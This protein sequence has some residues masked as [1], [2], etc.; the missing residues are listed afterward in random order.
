M[1]H[2]IRK[3]PEESRRVI[4]SAN[5]HAGARQ[6]NDLIDRLVNE[7]IAYGCD[8]QV[9]TDADEL[10]ELAEAWT[11]SGDLRAV[12]AAGGDG[13]AAFVANRVPHQTP[14]ALLPLG[15][16]NL[17]SKYLETTSDPV[18]LAE[19]IAL[20]SAVS[21]D[22]GQ[23]GERLFLLMCGVGFDAD[24][25]RRVHAERKGHIS[26]LAYA[27]PIFEA[28]RNYQYPEV[29]VT[30]RDAAGELQE[31]N[32]RW[33]FVV[34]VPRYAGGL[35]I[36]PD[37]EADDGLL[38]VCT[39]REGSFL[40]GLIYL[41]GVLFGQHQNWDDCG[42]M[43]A[44]EVR[45]TSTAEVPYQLDGDPGGVLPVEIKILPHRLSLLVCA[46]WARDHGY[47]SPTS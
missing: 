34:N 19:T 21:L 42:T 43:R 47:D 18:K 38:N 14:L 23:A 13:T 24:V 3:L 17:L 6:R 27:K 10:T 29:H 12:V 39:F 2:A 28:I 7:L 22:A 26:H 37:A 36:S 20:G 11:A 25:V 8:A 45:I 44:S 15:T 41:S 30:C 9:T 46:A 5:P 40:N 35:A 31:L 33:V 16:E 32:A 4:I 1:S